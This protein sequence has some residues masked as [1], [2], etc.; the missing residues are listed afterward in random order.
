MQEKSTSVMR[1]ICT[2]RKEEKVPFALLSSHSSTPTLSS[3][4]STPTFSSHSSTPT[5]SS[6]SILLTTLIPRLPIRKIDTNSRAIRPE[7]RAAII[8]RVVHARLPRRTRK[9][10]KAAAEIAVQGHAKAGAVGGGGAALREL[11]R[12]V[13]ACG[14]VGGAFGEAATAADLGF[15]EDIVAVLLFIRG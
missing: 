10:A 11:L 7:R 15:R 5:L 8:A 14:A 3:H 2:S 1:I 13:E 6:H 4:S 9:P 12:G